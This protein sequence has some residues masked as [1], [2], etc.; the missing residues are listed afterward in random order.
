VS[1]CYNCG[2]ELRDTA[3]YC[4]YCGKEQIVRH[5]SDFKHSG[6]RKQLH[7][8]ICKSTNIVPIVNGQTL[9]GTGTAIGLGSGVTIGLVN[10]KT[11]NKYGWLCKNCG[12]AFD[13]V[14]ELDKKISYYK[15]VQVMAVFCMSVAIIATIYALITHI[16]SLMWVTIPCVVIFGIIFVIAKLTANSTVQ[17]KLYLEK[18]CFD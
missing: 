17:Q 14:E 11:T 4:D 8:P 10:S 18:S 16:D 9:D 7:C 2:K 12:R 3:K 5:N 13:R 6:N 1:Y 15:T